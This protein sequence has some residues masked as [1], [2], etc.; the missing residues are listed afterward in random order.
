MSTAPPKVFISYSQESQT[1]SDKVL[2]LANQL[3]L[4]GIDVQIDRYVS[5]PQ[6]WAVWMSQQLQSG[7]FILMI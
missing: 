1:H 6:G 5:P 4:D 2:A 7:D 3:I